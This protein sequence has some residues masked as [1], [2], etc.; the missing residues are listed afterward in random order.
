LGVALVLASCDQ[1]RP[2]GPND[3]AAALPSP[4]SAA[5]IA[6]HNR[7][8]SKLDRFY[9]DGVITLRW[10]DD[11]G[12]HEEQADVELWMDRPQRAALRIHK[13]GEEFLYAGASERGA[14]LFDLRNDDEPVAHL[15]QPGQSLAVDA[16]SPIDL[17]PASL[18]DLLGLTVLPGDM[19]LVDVQTD[20]HA[21]QWLATLPRGDHA[22]SI[23]FDSKTFLPT[24]IE[25]RFS[26]SGPPLRSALVLDSYQSVELDGMAPGDYPKLARR[27][28]IDDV[29]REDDEISIMI[30]FAS[31]R[32]ADQNDRVFDIDLLMKRFEP[33]RIEGALAPP[34]AINEPP[35]SRSN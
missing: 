31:G 27:I 30:G 5:L 11:K 28:R 14:W 19:K 32:A 4:D 1:Q 33:T 35:S 2:R 24:A 20:A 7:R 18:T 9:A 26:A 3:D 10:R 17:D 16:S 23:Q 8:V 13:L 15:A 25:S 22:V 21:P 29:A 6:Q 34:G 12:R